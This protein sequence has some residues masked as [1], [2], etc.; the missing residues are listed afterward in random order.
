VSVGGEVAPLRC[1]Q[2]IRWPAGVSH[3]LWTE[4]TQMETLMVEHHE[5]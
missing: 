4:Q 1:G 5:T 2:S 3:R